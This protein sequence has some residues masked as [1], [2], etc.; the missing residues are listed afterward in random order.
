MNENLIVDHCLVF[1]VVINFKDI[2][3]WQMPNMYYVW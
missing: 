1:V 3:F 2:Q